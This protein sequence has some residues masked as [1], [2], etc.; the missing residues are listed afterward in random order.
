MTAEPQVRPICHRARGPRKARYQRRSTPR[1]FPGADQGPRR[2]HH[3]HRRQAGSMSRRRTAGRRREYVRAKPHR[4]RC[5]DESWGQLLHRRHRLRPAGPL[6]VNGPGQRRRC[7]NSLWPGTGPA[8]S[9]GFVGA[10]HS[11]RRHSS[12]FAKR[13]RTPS[14]GPLKSPNN[15]ACCCPTRRP[16]AACCCPCPS[17]IWIPC[18]ANLR[19]SALLTG[20]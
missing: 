14:T 1:R 13:S 7:Q 18:L 15:T 6:E 19:R 3:N 2:R 20:R 8:R 12:Q 9:L 5:D 16:P 11:P 4:C 10:R 17:P